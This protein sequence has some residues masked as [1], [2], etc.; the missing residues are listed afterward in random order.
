MLKLLA[1]IAR[2]LGCENLEDYE[3]PSAGIHYF[4]NN[5]PEVPATGTEARERQVMEFLSQAGGE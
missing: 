2:G 5:P 4:L 3:P 1:L